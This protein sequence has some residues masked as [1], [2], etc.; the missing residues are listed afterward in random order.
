MCFAGDWNEGTWTLNE[1]KSKI[2]PGTAVNKKVVYTVQGDSMKCV[3]DGVDANGKPTH[4]EW[5]GK[6]DGKDYAVTGDP[7]ADTRAIK[8]LNDWKYKLNNKKGGKIVSR[9]SIEFSKDGKTRTL[10]VHSTGADGK[11]RSYTAVYEKS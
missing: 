11:K 1:S 5:I 7:S 2:A 4:N 8:K 10:T 6:F 3:V 9:G